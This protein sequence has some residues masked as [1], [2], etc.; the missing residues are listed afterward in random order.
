MYIKSLGLFDY[1]NY[2]RKT[3]N[4]DRHLNIIVGKNGTGKTNILESIIVVSNTKSFRTSNDR[5]LIKKDEEFARIDLNTN[6]NSFRV[7]INKRNKSLYID[8]RLISRSSQFIGK[9]NA[10]LFKPSDLELFT[11]SPAERRKLLDIEISKISDKY[12]QALLNY[13]SLVKDKNKLLKEEK[14]DEV[15]FDVFNES[16]IPMIKTIIAERERFFDAINRYI[17]PIYSK[18]SGKDTEIRVTY[19]KCAEIENVAEELKNS[20]D[21]DFYYH[22]A[23]F[24]PHHEDYSFK[25][26]GYD[27]NSIA[28]QGQ[29]RMALIAFKFALVKYIQTETGSTPIILLDDI[30]SELDKENQERL[31]S[32]IPEYAQIIITNTDINNIKIK[33]DYR[34]IEL[35]EEN[36]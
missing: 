15:L 12:I 36:V 18:I 34:L 16:M 5:D 20:K 11:Q 29:K 22:Y 32:S 33:R 1:R 4:F 17:S 28:S 23:T 2:S 30:L 24:G 35:E 8:E 7:V 26:D 25:M 9:V 13:N 21:K 14:V 31:L 3:L 10:I 6:K 19:K 27:I